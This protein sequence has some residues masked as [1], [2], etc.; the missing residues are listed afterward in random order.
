MLAE[1]DPSD[2]IR[3]YNFNRKKLITEFPSMPLN[4]QR[5]I[6]KKLLNREMKGG[7]YEI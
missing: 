6:A 1:L 2:P 7:G 4:R 5:Y 3:L